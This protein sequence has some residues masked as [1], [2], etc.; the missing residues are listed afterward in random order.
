VI[1]LA[2]TAC[3]DR[4]SAGRG[5]NR[6]WHPRWSA[7]VPTFRDARQSRGCALGSRPVPDR[8]DDRGGPG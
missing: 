8:P 5:W 6:H 2:A 4:M 1:P 3:V 7:G